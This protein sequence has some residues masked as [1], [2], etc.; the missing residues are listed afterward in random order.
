MELIGRL[1]WPLTVLLLAWF[2]RHEVRV[3]FGR[4]QKAKLPGGAELSFGNPTADVPGE[5]PFTSAGPEQATAPELD[6]IG[7][8]YWLGHDIMWTIDVLLRN[9]SPEVILHGLRSSLHH[10]QQA[11]LKETSFQ[12]VLQNMKSG[13][14]KTPESDWTPALRDLRAIELRQLSDHVGALVAS[15]QIDFVPRPPDER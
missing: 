10:L 8:I 7:S 12:S 5:S 2:L 15:Q 3:A 11:G 13:A 4:M 14:E 9:A 6:K 1:A